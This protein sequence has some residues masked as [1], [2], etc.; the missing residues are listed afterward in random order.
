M[1]KRPIDAI[2]DSA[3]S[4]A[5]GRGEEPS[6]I[7]DFS[8][9]DG[10]LHVVKERSIYQIT[11]ADAI[12]PERTDPSVPNTQQRVLSYGSS[13]PPRVCRR[14]FGLSHA[15]MAGSSSMA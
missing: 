3:G 9:I 14:R 6:P 4:M 15:A 5:V 7:T 2:R 10:R 12:D 11:M 13:E 1:S 8:V